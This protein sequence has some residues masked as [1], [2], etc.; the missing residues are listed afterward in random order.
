[1]AQKRIHSMRQGGVLV[2]EP[3]DTIPSHLN[4]RQ[5]KLLARTL[6]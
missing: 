6:R 3:I 2:E 1:M 4:R 5:A